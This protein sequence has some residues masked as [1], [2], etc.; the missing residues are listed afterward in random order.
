MPERDRLDQMYDEPTAPSEG[1]GDRLD[2]IYAEKEPTFTQRALQ[3]SYDVLTGKSGREFLGGAG[4]A[5]LTH[6][7][8]LSDLT[9]QAFGL[10][11]PEIRKRIPPP[12]TPLGQFGASTEELGEWV[13]PMGEEI[14]GTTLVPRLLRIG[15]EALRGGLIGGAQT[16][17]PEGA[18]TGAQTGALGGS[19][20]EAAGVT[21]R[22]MLLK[23]ARMPPE[24]ARALAVAAREMGPLSAAQQQGLT[25]VQKVERELQNFPGAGGARAQ[26]FFAGEEERLGRWGERIAARTGVPAA[27]VYEAG[28]GVIG[29][30]RQRIVRRKGVADRLYGGMRQKTAAAQEV[31]QTGTREVPGPKPRATLTPEGM[32]RTE[33][34][35]GVFEAPVELVPFRQALQPVFDELTRLMPE[36]R[37]ANSNAYAVFKDLMTST[38]THMNAMDFD[39]SLGAIKAL[40]RDGESLYL[41]TPSQRLVKIYVGEAEKR[42]SDA[43]AKVSPDLEPRL[44]MA[45]RAVRDYH[46]TD[47]FLLD[48]LGAKEEPGVLYHNL[49]TGGSKNVETLKELQRLAPR[50]LK[51]VGRTYFEQMLKKA[52]EEGGFHRAEGIIREFEHL[53][54]EQRNLLL[55]PQVAQDVWNYLLA[56]KRLAPAEGS[57][58]AGRLLALTLLGGATSVISGAITYLITGDLKKGGEAMG[59]TLVTGAVGLYLVPNIAARMLLTPGGARLVTQGIT[60]GPGSRAAVRAAEGLVARG[61]LAQQ[62]ERADRAATPAPEAAPPG[63]T[64]PAAA[65][66]ATPPAAAPPPAPERERP[67]PL[68]ARAEQTLPRPD[69][70]PGPYLTELSPPEERAFQIW[71]KSNR[72][73]FDPSPTADYDMRGFYRAMQAGQAERSTTN[74]HFPDTWK[75]PWH[76]TFSNES[77]YATPD[78]PR[79]E[80][81][82]LIDKS[83]KVVADESAPA[84]PRAAGPKAPSFGS[85]FPGGAQKLNEALAAASRRSRVPLN[86]LNAVARL[87]NAPG[88]PRAVSKKGAVGMLQL[89]PS[90]FAQYGRGNIRN[91]AD[92]IQAGAHYLRY[93]KNTYGSWELALA[94]YNAGEGAVARYRG[95]PPYRETEDYVS[96][97]IGLIRETPEE[98]RGR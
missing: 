44:Q 61:M 19:F 95:V 18:R 10:K 80:G 43:L 96:K 64:T 93:L 30:L 47:E 57:A 13:I 66:G 41:T 39:K 3:A 87:E 88:D 94:A 65:A 23:K 97:G 5:A 36:A 42:L 45:R 73:P 76:K 70:K 69:A 31:V 35:F 22:G 71:V 52:T 24:Q 74:L 11:D 32:P 78:A 29:R 46:A 90:T 60:A 84:A 28:K 25:G 37:R 26:E 54:P 81:N 2:Q 6:L 12:S 1:K 4:T 98:A 51:T 86:V 9:L 75:T 34:V 49:V 16:G 91:P 63:A 89:L 55:G 8:G 21:G 17:T 82:R 79:W 67:S 33:P 56:A 40:T 62:Q 7:A 59:G 38:Q 68:G 92:N 83:G 77:M 15:K 85:K 72:I 20:G 14:K 58:T 27:S 50:E 48:I 53:G